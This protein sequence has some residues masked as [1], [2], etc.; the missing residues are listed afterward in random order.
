MATI[1][2]GA[3]KFNWKGAYNSSTSYAVDDVVSSGGNSYVCIQAH[4]NQAVGNATAYWNIMSSAGTNGTN[5][6][7]LTSTL[8]AQ[9]DILYRDGSG[10]AKLG[11]GTSGQLL[12]TGGSGANPSW[13]TVSG[14]KIKQTHWQWDDQQAQIPDADNTSSTGLEAISYSFTAQSNNPHFCLDFSMFHG[15]YHNDADSGDIYVI[16]YIE[17]SGTLRYSF[18]FK[19]TGGF[20]SNATFRAQ[21]NSFFLDDT[22]A[23]IYANNDNNWC[24]YR[25]TYAG[26]MGNQASADTTA[27]PS[28]N[29]TAGDTLTLKIK[30]GGNGTNWYNRT[31]GQSNSHSRSWF[32]LQELDNSL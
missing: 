20:R 19:K 24:G 2:L 30:L 9:G 27:S 14:G 3:I 11:A 13:T 10:L 25:L 29:I 16:A 26:V 31:S 1:N 4:S 23:G 22:D 18:G 32:K 12:Q 17:E 8:T 15:T 7:D 6:T 21:S 5:G 28:T